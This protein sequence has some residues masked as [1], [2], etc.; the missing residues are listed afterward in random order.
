MTELIIGDTGK[1]SF[2]YQKKDFKGG[3]TANGTIRAVEID[4]VMF[5]DNDGYLYLVKRDEFNFEKDDK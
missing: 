5:E 1:A 3:V 2:K 4:Y